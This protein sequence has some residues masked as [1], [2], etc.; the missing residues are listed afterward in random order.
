M[1]FILAVRPSLLP[2]LANRDA[3]VQTCYVLL[4]QGKNGKGLPGWD[5]SLEY[6]TAEDLARSMRC[7]GNRRR[8]HQVGFAT[9]DMVPGRR[10]CTLAITGAQLGAELIHRDSSTGDMLEVI[11][12]VW[13]E[14]LFTVGS[15]CSPYSHSKQLGN[16]G[17][18]LTVAALLGKYISSG[19]VRESYAR[20]AALARRAAALNN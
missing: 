14:M 15:K 13:L 1:V 3:Y 7:L 11:L 18:L 5:W 10:D 20:A 6:K 2:P 12:Q 9:I 19:I 4:P 17:E 16:G 8:S